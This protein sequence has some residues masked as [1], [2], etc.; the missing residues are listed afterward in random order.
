S[1]QGHGDTIM[2]ARFVRQVI[3][4]GARVIL[5]APP[6]LRELLE[7][8]DGA[9]LTN[10]AEAA[11]AFDLYCPLMSVPQALNVT[12]ETVAADV[13]YLAA[14]AANLEKWRRRLPNS[15]GLKVGVNW[16]GNPEFR[17]DE[18]RSI[19]LQRMLPL[20]AQADVQ[21]FSLQK[22]LRDGDEEL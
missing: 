1:E 22:E 12:L 13:P 8:L 3:G 20:L 21:F 5:D 19:G 15:G 7:Q 11:P 14:P 17:H 9:T 18:I 4:M 2:A 16:A 6:A 10:P